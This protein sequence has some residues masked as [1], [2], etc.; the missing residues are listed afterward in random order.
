MTSTVICLSLTAML[1]MSSVAN[2]TAAA[3]KTQSRRVPRNSANASTAA[4]SQSAASA[5]EATQEEGE[6]PAT[7]ASNGKARTAMQ[8][9]SNWDGG[10]FQPSPNVK[11]DPRSG[12]YAIWFTDAPDVLNLPFVKVWAG[13]C[14]LG[15]HGTAARQV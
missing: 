2:S 8:L 5:E 4:S 10:F 15:R 7:P 12:I 13:G 6:A 9:P 11:R 3:A 1:L 14:T